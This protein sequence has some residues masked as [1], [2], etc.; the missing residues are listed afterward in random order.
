MLLRDGRTE[1]PGSS[2]TKKQIQRKKAHEARITT[3]FQKLNGTGSCFLC[4]CYSVGVKHEKENKLR[5]EW[6]EDKVQGGDFFLRGLGPE[7]F[8]GSSAN[9]SGVQLPP[10]QLGRL[11]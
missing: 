4:P 8:V 5:R 11:W 3:N 2:I 10:A 9:T 6:G 1:N 7:T